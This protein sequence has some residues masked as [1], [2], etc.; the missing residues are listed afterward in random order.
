MLN[1]LPFIITTESSQ[2]PMPNPTISEVNASIAALNDGVQQVRDFLTANPIT[3]SAQLSQTKDIIAVVAAN[4]S[5]LKA[6][7][8]MPG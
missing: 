7:L 8:G 6:Q 2:Q 1:H 5:N 3:T 4:I